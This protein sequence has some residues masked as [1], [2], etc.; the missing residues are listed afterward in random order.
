MTC[1]L[2]RLAVLPTASSRIKEA[3]NISLQTR[4]WI[5]TICGFRTRTASGSSRAVLMSPPED[6]VSC[7]KVSQVRWWERIITS[8]ERSEEHT[9]ELQSRGHLVCRLLLEKKKNIETLAN[10]LRAD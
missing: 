10:E 4:T 3:V 9:S 1:Q 5:M 6:S 8:E 2:P 7:W